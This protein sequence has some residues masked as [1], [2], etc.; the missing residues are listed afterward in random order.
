SMKIVHRLKSLTIALIA[1]ALSAGLAFGA[2]PQSSGAW[3]RTNAA[4]HAGKTVP[5]QG[6]EDST[7]EAGDEDVDEGVDETVDETAGEEE[8]TTEEGD[9]VSEE[10]SAEDGT[11]CATDP[12]LLTEEELAAMNHGS[13]VCWAAHQTE[14]PEEFKNKGAWVS[15]WA[16]AG[17]GHGPDAAKVKGKDKAKGKTGADD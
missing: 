5:V 7:D 13:V 2:Q 8:E 1:L 11:N 17:K 4:Q 16:H 14:W 6:A 15:S 12:T 3:G 10:E 9:E